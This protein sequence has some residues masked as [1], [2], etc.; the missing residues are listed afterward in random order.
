CAALANM[1]RGLPLSPTDRLGLFPASV[2]EVLRVEGRVIDDL[3]LL[4]FTCVRC[5][6]G[7][8]TKAETS[9]RARATAAALPPPGGEKLVATE[10]GVVTGAEPKLNAAGAGRC[11]CSG[12]AR[13]SVG[14]LT[15]FTYETK[16]VLTL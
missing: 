9:A 15:R 6:V 11:G 13:L 14:S 2:P 12:V 8:R 4:L 5:R 3:L 1:R 10:V 16:D 7:A